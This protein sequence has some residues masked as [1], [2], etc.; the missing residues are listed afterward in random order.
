MYEVYD[1]WPEIAL[2]S[3]ESEQNP[4][5]FD[6]INHI[7]FAGMGGSGA[8]GDLFAAILSKTK[9]HVNVV[10]GYH[11]P[12]TVDP[13]SLVI[14]ISVSGNTKETI[15]VLDSAFNLGSK[16]IAFSSGG[17][18]EEYCKKNKIEHRRIPQNHSPRASFTS[19][20]YSILK[21]L[22]STLEIKQEDILESI[23]EMKK[24]QKKINSRNLTEK[25][26]A[27]NLAKWIDNVP[28]IY[29]PFGLESATIRFKNSLQ[30]NTKLHVMTEDVIEA[31][32][33]GIVSWERKSSIQPILIEGQNDH[34]KTKE[35]W[36]IL[37]E[38]FKKRNIEYKEIKSINGSILTKLVNLIYLLDYASIYLA[39]LNKID[40]SPV[41]SI[42]FIKERLEKQ[43]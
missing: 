30:E 3:F 16:I 13:N 14:T 23:A 18:M 42:D 12:K 26:P 29:Y 24:M 43:N 19:F 1:K 22:H 40:P 10:K 32:H 38:F 35:R 9:I 8:I 41:K 28:I 7:V 11:L 34:I 31:C 27:L 4:I 6:K 20:L 15:S 37:K 2:K 17:E 5:N 21:V 39:V 33:N 36:I 25:N